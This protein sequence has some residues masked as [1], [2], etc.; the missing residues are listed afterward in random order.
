MKKPVRIWVTRVK[1][2]WDLPS[3]T[4]IRKEPR[5]VLRTRCG[6]CASKGRSCVSTH[7]RKDGSTFPVEISVRYVQLDR[8]YFVT[9]A[10]DIS[11]RKRSERALRESEDRYRDLV[12]H[13]EDLVCTH[14]LTGKLLSVNPSSARLL[15]YEPAE[16][17]QISMRNL[18]APEFRHQFD[19][20]LTRIRTDWAKRT[21]RL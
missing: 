5:F 8:S 14:D 16:L 21:R 10:R 11:A 18:I 3:S 20:Y 19:E 6:D 7:K 17:L 1:N 12:E 15:G 4:S 2:Y 9:V 13:S